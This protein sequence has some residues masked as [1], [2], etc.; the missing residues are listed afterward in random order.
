MSIMSRNFSMFLLV[1]RLR[2]LNVII[3]PSSLFIKESNKSKYYRTGNFKSES[4]SNGDFNQINFKLLVKIKN[5]VY[6]SKNSGFVSHLELTVS[7]LYH[8][9]TS[10]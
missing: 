8:I 5:T 9:M 10:Y 1:F 4:H 7:D 3:F 6:S 2:A